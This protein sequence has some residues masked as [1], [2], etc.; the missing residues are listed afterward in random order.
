MNKIY[1]LA[2]AAACTTLVV[3]ACNKQ[4]DKTNPERNTVRISNL[5]EACECCASGTDSVT[6]PSSTSPGADYCVWG[7]ATKQLCASGPSLQFEGQF[8]SFIRPASANWYI[9]TTE[10]SYKDS[11]WC[12]ISTHIT[13]KNLTGNVGDYPDCGDSRVQENV[14]GLNGSFGGQ[15]FGLGYFSYVTGVPTVQKSI[16][17]WSGGTSTPDDPTG[18]TC[19]YVITVNNLRSLGGPGNWFGRVVYSY[20]CLDTGCIQ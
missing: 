2:I 20:R 14:L 5:L 8:S 13:A 10:L 16:V 11:S 3:V 9:G 1:K 17:I 7:T 18:A 12:W 4:Y 15:N 19:A 6:G